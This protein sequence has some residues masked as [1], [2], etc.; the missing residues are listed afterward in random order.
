[1]EA[2]ETER[3]QPEQAL[4]QRENKY[5]D[6]ADFLPQTAFELDEAGNL[7]FVNLNSFEIFHHALEDSDKGWNVLKMFIPGDRDRVKENIQ[8]VLTGKEVSGAEY[9]AISGDGGTFPVLLYASP[10]WMKVTCTI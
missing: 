1:M 10:I 6:F 9:M 7:T 4:R 8:M 2:S 3:K 5:R